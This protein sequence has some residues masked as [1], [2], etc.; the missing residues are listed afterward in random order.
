MSDIISIG[1]QAAVITLILVIPPEHRLKPEVAVQA[2]L[3]GIST[4]LTMGQYLR[5]VNATAMPLSVALEK[6]TPQQSGN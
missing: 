3:G 2:F 4:P 6:F 5:T 1:E